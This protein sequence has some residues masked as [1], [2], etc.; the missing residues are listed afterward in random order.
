MS[1]TCFERCGSRSE[2]SAPDWPWRAN[3]ERRAEQLR[4]A[5]DEREPFAFDDVFG[6]G[7]AVVLIQLRLGVEEI[8][9]RGRAGHEQVDDALRAWGEV[10]TDGGVRRGGEAVEAKRRLSSSDVSA[11]A[12]MPK[13]LCWKKWRRV[14]S[15]RRVLC[16]RDLV[17]RTSSVIG[18]RRGW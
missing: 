3:F 5:F 8:E 15:R 2:S 17:S 16:V 10:R 12:P 1:S 18:V 9:L 4:R 6:D 11:S 7:L 13:P 14:I